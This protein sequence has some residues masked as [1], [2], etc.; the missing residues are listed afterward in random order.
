M[1]GS[2]LEHVFTPSVEEIEEGVMELEYDCA[3]D[4]YFGKGKKVVKEGL[5]SGVFSCEN[6]A[7]K[8]E[9]DWNMVYVARVEGNCDT[10][11]VVW[12]FQ[13]KEGVEVGKVKLLVGSTCYESGVVSW[14]LC[15]QTTC[16]VPTA[17]QMLDTEQLTGSKE[18]KLS[19]RLEGGVGELAW[20]HTQLFR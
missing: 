9:S 20:Q 19:A 18:I 14:Q 17:G 7:R 6:I 13:M 5:L 15:S 3:M 16:L 11:E 12:K 1:G 10:G 2:S 8:V 4:K